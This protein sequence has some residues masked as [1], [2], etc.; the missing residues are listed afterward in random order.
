MEKLITEK[1]KERASSLSLSPM[2]MS[3]GI[4]KVD[5]GDE[6]SSSPKSK[7]SQILQAIFD[8]YAMIDSRR[9]KDYVSFRDTYNKEEKRKEER[10]QELL[11]VLGV[12]TEI[13]IKQEPTPKAEKLPKV[14]AEKK[15]TVRAA[16]KI[17]PATVSKVSKKKRTVKPGLSI[18]KPANPMITTAAKV[19]ATALVGTGLASMATSAIAKEEGFAE[20]AYNDAGKVSIGYGHQI[21]EEEYKQGFIEIGDERV[22]IK[23]N[24]GLDTRITKDQAN[25]LLQIDLPK[26]EKAAKDP[27]G[28]SWNKLNDSQKS[29]L[30][31]YAY[32]VGST[33]SLV[34]AGL[35]E[36]IDSGDMAKAAQIIREKGIATSEGKTNP[37]LV[38]RRKREADIFEKGAKSGSPATVIPE[39]PLDSISKM[40]KDLNEQ[41]NDLS[42]IM[43]TVQ[44][45]NITNNTQTQPSAPQVQ[46]DRPVHERK[47]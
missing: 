27:L 13:P 34:R 31:S 20:K 16:R 45:V 1:T 26:Y 24:R 47:R 38:E 33:A 35:K 10:H 7:V 40:N 9:Q 12:T 14:K 23:G 5:N 8:L 28:D 41:L 18:G 15:K 3:L 42:N 39:T 6:S 17:K 43:T 19:A 37:V 46:D 4:P 22:E 2:R 11:S 29:A 30:V 25:K 21:K 32:N 44:N 36:A